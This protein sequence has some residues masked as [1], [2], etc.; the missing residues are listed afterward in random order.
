MTLLTEQ[1]EYAR[2]K[3]ACRRGMLEL[4]LMLLPFFE[5]QFSILSIKAKKAF[6]KLLECPDP[7]IFNWLMAYSETDDDELKEIIA[8]IRNAN[9]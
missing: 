1:N 7:D 9:H 3:W 2:I 4:D 8:I 5:Q 6:I